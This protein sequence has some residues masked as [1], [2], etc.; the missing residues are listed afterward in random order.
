[1]DKIDSF[2]GEYEFL[3]NFYDAPVT[4]DGLTYRNSEAA[5]QAQKVLEKD[6]RVG[7]TKLNPTEA[8]KL[9]RCV[10]LRKDWN[11]VKVDI[12]HAVVKAKFTQNPELAKKLIDTGDAYLEEGNTWGDRIWGTVNGQGANNLG[13]ILMAVREKLIENDRR[14]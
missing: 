6:A 1:M 7:F 11:D 10:V 3:S 8:K 4:F 12:M 14:V 9:G 2:S 5:F 13:K